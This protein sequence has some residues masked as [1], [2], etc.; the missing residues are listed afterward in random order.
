MVGTVG[1]PNKGFHEVEEVCIGFVSFISKVFQE[2]L[3]SLKQRKVFKTA[4]WSLQVPPPN[5]E[6]R[7]SS[8][9]VRGSLKLQ[10]RRY[11]YLFRYLTVY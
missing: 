8:V 1:C 3:Q 6:R 7:L 10:P 5:T 11:R 9:E 2:L 4:V